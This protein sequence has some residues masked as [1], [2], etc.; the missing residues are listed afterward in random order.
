MMFMIGLIILMM[1]Q[2]LKSVNM[3]EVIP[4][5]SMMFLL[6]FSEYSNITSELFFMDESSKNMILLTLFLYII[7]SMMTFDKGKFMI[8][9]LSFLIMFLFFMSST[10]I[11]MFIMFECSLLPIM[12]LINMYGNQPERIMAVRYM[13]MYTTLTS[14]PLFVTIIYLLNKEFSFIV[15]H[16][17]TMDMPVSMFM[18]ISLLLAFLVKIP[19]FLVHTWLPKAHVEA[20]MEGSIILAGIMLKMGVF[21]VIRMMMEF[22]CLSMLTKSILMM[23]FLVGCILSSWISISV[24]DMKMNV[25]FSSISHMNFVM[26][27]LM[28][29]KVLSLKSCILVMLSH[30]LCSALMFFLVTVYYYKTNSRSFIVSKGVMAQYPTMVMVFFFTWVMNMACPPSVSFF[31]ELMCMSSLIMYSVITLPLMMVFIIINSFFCIFSFGIMC[32]SNVKIQFKDQINSLMDKLTTWSLLAPLMVMFIS[33]EM[34]ICKYIKMFTLVMGF[35]ILEKSSHQ[36][37]LIYYLA[38]VYSEDLISLEFLYYKY[39]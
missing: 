24:D 39:I 3:K 34:I 2:L 26:A 29:N 33:L 31:G 9:L 21:G 17:L 20:P 4:S 35:S 1:L 23:I 11:M 8:I 30:G 32:H 14:V 6:I 7:L 36:L 28:T 15:F 16:Q 13:M 37:G 12:L 38:D 27:G 25:A 5:I 22:Y 18:L 19:M 10:Y